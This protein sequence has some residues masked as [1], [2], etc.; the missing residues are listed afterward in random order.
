MSWSVS[1]V[2]QPSVEP[3][4]LAEAKSHL[5]V[6][7]DDEDTLI[8][9]QIIAAREWVEDYIGYVTVQRQ[10]RLTLD[11]LPAGDTI[12][13]P[14]SKLISIDSV[15]YVDRDGVTQTWDASNY[16]ADTYAE[17][18]RLIRDPDSDWP[19]VRAQRQAVIITYTAG[20]PDDGASPPDY[21]ANVPES[22]KAAIKLTL[23]NLYENRESVIVGTIATELPLAVKSLLAAHRRIYIR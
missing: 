14:R 11:Y 21:A 9:A 12:T 5:R 16:S 23:G 20:W 17:E 15:E 13:L 7:H 22:I 8:Q 1:E 4:S 3:V 6:D 2:T 19:N 18:G 10:L